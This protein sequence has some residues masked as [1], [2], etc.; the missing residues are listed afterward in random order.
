M[1]DRQF[2]ADILNLDIV[3]DDVPLQPGRQRLTLGCIRI[4]KETI[5]PGGNEDMPV[6]FAFRVQ[7]AGLYRE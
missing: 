6:E 1:Q 7:N 5:R 2:F 3:G 4:E